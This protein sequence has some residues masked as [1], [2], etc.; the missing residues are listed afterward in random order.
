MRLWPGRQAALVALA[1]LLLLPACGRKGPPL[2]PRPRVPAAVG[3]LLAE[4][5]GEGVLV[6][7]SRPIRNTDGSPLTDL[8]EFRLSRNPGPG[9]SGAAPGFALVATIRAADPDNAVLQ[10]GRYAFQ[11]TGGTSGLRPGQRYSYR[12]QPVNRQ[13]QLGA[14]AE[15][16]VVFSAAPG[17]PEGVRAAAGDGEVTVSWSTVPGVR[18]NVYRG[19]RPGEPGSRPLNAEPIRGGAFRDGGVTNETTYYYVVRAVASERP[20]WRE[21]P[22]SAEVAATPA[23]TTPPAPPRGLTAQPGPNGVVLTWA[24]GM[25]PDLLGYRVYRRDLPATSPRRLTDAPIAV[26][27][28]TDSTAPAG[29]RVR[30]SV[31]AVD[32]SAR[33][34]ESPPSAEVEVSGP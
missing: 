19:R 1:V 23:K 12:V 26:T 11:D 13:G 9:P 28:F 24:P 17:P 31:T 2:P 3:G 16:A 8:L 20:P 27:T 29:V 34:N 10:N 14:A 33:Q 32:R 5:V 21:S 15:T 22:D 7:W 4:P 18:Y 6:S 25:E 30:Y